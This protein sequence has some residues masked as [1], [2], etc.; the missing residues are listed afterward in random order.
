[1]QQDRHEEQEPIESKPAEGGSVLKEIEEQAPE[2]LDRLTPEQRKKLGGLLELRMSKFYRAPLPPAED[3]AVYNEHIPD[4]GNRIMCMAEEALRSH[5]E[6][7]RTQLKQSGRGQVFGLS[8]GVLGIV[9]GAIVALLGCEWVGAIIAGST[10][11]SLATALLT[12]Q[13]RVRRKQN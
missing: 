11:V 12:G 2:V 8:I 10:A 1:M 13:R 7:Q 4:G 5:I 6:T 3:I 9:T